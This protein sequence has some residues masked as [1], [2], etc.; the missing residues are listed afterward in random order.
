MPFNSK[1]MPAAFPALT[2]TC[3]VA[4]TEACAGAIRVSWATGLPSAVMETQLVSS[5]RISTLKVLGEATGAAGAVLSSAAR[6]TGD[7]FV[8]GVVAALLPESVE[9]V[10]GESFADDDL[11]ASNFFSTFSEAAALGDCFECDAG[12]GTGAAGGA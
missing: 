7:E 2:M 3:P 5:A 4:R 10:P 8:G 9:I 11:S 1:L 6:L 12:A